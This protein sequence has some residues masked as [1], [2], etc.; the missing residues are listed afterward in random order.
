MAGG[1]RKR[2][3]EGRFA[4]KK[5][6][7]KPTAKLRELEG[8]KIMRLE[9]IYK[10]TAESGSDYFRFCP[11]DG[12]KLNGKSL[13]CEKCSAMWVDT[14]LALNHENCHLHFVD[15]RD[16]L[17]WWQKCC[18]RRLTFS[19]HSGVSWTSEPPVPY[20]VSREVFEDGFE[21]GAWETPAFKTHIR[22]LETCSAVESFCAFHSVDVKRG[23]CYDCAWLSLTALSTVT[24]NLWL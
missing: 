1:E 14:V 2:Q 16:F 4:D 10:L 23:F 7:R 11:K 8:D 9:G 15:D 13:A 24:C 22:L 5:R 6:P 12:S 20:E 19:E 21:E 3:V 18:F 17:K